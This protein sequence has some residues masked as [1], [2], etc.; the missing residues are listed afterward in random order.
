MFKPVKNANISSEVIN[1]IIDVISFMSG[2]NG[3]YQ[4]QNIV[5]FKEAFNRRFENQEVPLAVVLD[6]ELG[7]GYPVSSAVNDVNKL[8]DDLVFPM[9]NGSLPGGGTYSPFD[10]VL[11][12][13]YIDAIKKGNDTIY[14][15]NQD[16]SN[17]PIKNILDTIGVMFSIVKDDET[18]RLI[19]FKSSG[20]SSG[21][22]LLGRFSHI[23]SSILQFVKE[24]ADKEKE[25]NDDKIIAEI[26]HLPESRI[27]NIASRPKF[28]DYIIHYLSNVDTVEENAISISDLMISLKNDRI[29]LR[30]KKLDKEII[31]R[32]TCAHNYSM[33]PIPIYRFLCDIQHQYV[34]SGFSFGWG[35]IFSSFDYLPRIK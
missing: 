17:T 3:V 24:I 8:V 18:G 31:P 20:G 6:N 7:F 4:N 12:Q 11:M 2:I 35:N 32:L 19:Y 26:S 9:H 28:R 5:S 10:V 21:A 13:K 22:N 1:E 15:N 23:D 29:C 30:S 27:G 25:Y 14:I 33:T 16:F 34:Q